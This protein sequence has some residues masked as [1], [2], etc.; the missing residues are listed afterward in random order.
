MSSPLRRRNSFYFAILELECMKKNIIY[1]LLP[2]LFITSCGKDEPIPP[3][4]TYTVKITA[5][6]GGSVSSTGGSYLEGTSF[7]VSATANSGYTFNGW[8]DGETSANRTIIVTGDISLTARFSRLK[9]ELVR[10]RILGTLELILF[11]IHF[12]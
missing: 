7:D 2:L 8:S 4:P 9:Y 12:G 5:E 6:T 3:R 11:E 10:G 1:F